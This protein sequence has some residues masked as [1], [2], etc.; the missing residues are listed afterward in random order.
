QGGNNAGH[1]VVVDDKA[2]ALRLLPSGILYDNLHQ[3]TTHSASNYKQRSAKKNYH[4]AFII[5]SPIN[6]TLQKDK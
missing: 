2:F 5:I 3:V 4:T 1:T 6:T